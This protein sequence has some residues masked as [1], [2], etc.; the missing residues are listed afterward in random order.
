MSKDE[1]MVKKTPT[2]LH[3]KKTV[4]RQWTLILIFC[5]D[6]HMGLDLP[7][8]TCVH[9]SL[10]PS[11]P[12]CGHHKWMTPKHG[13]KRPVFLFAKRFELHLQFWLIVVLILEVQSDFNLLWLFKCW[14]AYLLM[15]FPIFPFVF[16][17]SLWLWINRFCLNYWLSVMLSC[18]LLFDLWQHLVTV[19][20]LKA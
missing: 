18:R 14:V 19:A 7:P 6:V 10:T 20:L 12:P 1:I 8:S 4:W 17:D 11:P 2:S 9:L 16:N 5:V 15:L 13:C 3:E